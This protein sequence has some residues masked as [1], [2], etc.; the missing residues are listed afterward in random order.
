LMLAV[1]SLSWRRLLIVRCSL[2]F[3]SREPGV[4]DWRSPVV[5]CSLWFRC[6]NLEDTTRGSML[7]V[8]SI[9]GAWRGNLEET[10][11]GLMLAVVSLTSWFLSR[12]PGVE[13]WR[14]PSVVRRSLW[15]RC[16]NLEETTSSSVLAAVSLTSDVTVGHSV[17]LV[18]YECS[19]ANDYITYLARPASGKF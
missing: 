5:R 7:A 3:P 2:W 14:G 12:E 4:E 1:V 8:V 6:G 16:G 9:Q 11:R 19:A 10:T 17:I 15:I 18:S 13:T